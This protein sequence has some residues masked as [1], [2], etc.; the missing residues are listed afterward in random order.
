MSD[1]KDIALVISIIFN[2][3]VCVLLFF[4]SALNDIL[5]DWWFN[6]RTKKEEAIK[7][8]INFKREFNIKFSQ[9]LIVILYLAII[10]N[11]VIMGK[12]THQTTKKM[13]D[14]SIHKSTEARNEIAK[15]LDYLPVDLIN[16][17]NRYENEILE[18]IK[19]ILEDRVS[20]EDVLK[21]LDLIESLGQETNTLADSILRKNLVK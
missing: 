13:R 19:K 15:F 7:R 18:I 17:Y 10:S 20:K 2:I 6:R 9:D 1:P 8:L 14:D 12:E 4:R 3:I 21:Y 16:L 11:D 5:K